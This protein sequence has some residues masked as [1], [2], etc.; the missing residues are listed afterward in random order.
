[1]KR[2]IVAAAALLAGATTLPAQESGAKAEVRPFVGAS[3]PTGTQRDL[4]ND[5]PI[6]GLQGAVQL[7]PTL[8]LVGTFG[9]LPGQNEYVLT[10]DNVNVFAYDVGVELSMV[11]WARSSRSA[12]RPSEWKHGMMCSASARRSPGKT[13]RRATRS[14]SPRAL[15][16]T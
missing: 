16:T 14:G 6:F 4:F 9:W 10:R 5:A 2:A 7:K 13:P 12:A 8:H 1:M 3:I 11:R 15:P